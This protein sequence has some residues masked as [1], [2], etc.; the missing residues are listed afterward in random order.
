[1][2]LEYPDI[3]PALWWFTESLAVLIRDKENSIWSFI[4]RNS[5]RPAMLKQ[6]FNFIIGNPPWLSY[7]YISDPDYQDEIKRRAVTKYKIAPMSQKLFTQMELATVFLTHSMATFAK[8]DA[9]LGFVMPRGVLNS[10]QH[11]NLILRKY[12]TDAK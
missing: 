9:R 1:K 6:Q 5:Y 3:L 12:S 2:L 10:D 7:R 8:A 4:I 11:Q